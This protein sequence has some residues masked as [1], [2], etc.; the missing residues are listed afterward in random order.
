MKVP[1]FIPM[2][3]LDLFCVMSLISSFVVGPT[4]KFILSLAGVIAFTIGSILTG[5]YLIRQGDSANHH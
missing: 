1:V 2:I 5:G 3:L 4:W